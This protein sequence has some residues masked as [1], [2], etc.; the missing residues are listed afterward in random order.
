MAIRSAHLQI[1]VTPGEKKTLRRLAQAAGQDLSSFV[2]ARA[3]PSNRLRFQEILRAVG[4]DDHR[5][6]LAE[7]NDFLTALAPVEFPDAV[8]DS[9]VSRLSPFLSNYVAAMVE[10]GAYLKHVP[11]PPWAHHIA[12]L[13]APHFATP[14]KSLRLHL[15]AA[16]PVPFKRRNIFVD[17]SLGARV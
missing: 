8:Q 12:P 7:L 4:K 14:L 1:R 3:L 15:L 9:D 2:L 5:F 13:E 11:P 6:A 17:A 16:S 10:L